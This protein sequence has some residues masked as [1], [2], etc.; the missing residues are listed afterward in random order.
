M[1]VPVRIPE[2]RREWVTFTVLGPDLDA[3]RLT[4]AERLHELDAWAGWVVLDMRVR[5]DS[6][7]AA[8]E[9]EVEAEA[10][11]PMEHRSTPRRWFRR[12]A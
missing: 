4:V 5:R 3:L 9:C 2:V 10:H 1:T 8:W 11:D 6:T 7:D 12:S